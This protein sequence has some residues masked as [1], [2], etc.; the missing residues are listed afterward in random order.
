M[1][2][3]HACT[4]QAPDRA[5][6]LL[7][8]CDTLRNGRLGGPGKSKTALRKKRLAIDWSRRTVGQVKAVWIHH[9]PSTATH[10]TPPHLVSHAFGL[11]P[12]DSPLPNAVRPGC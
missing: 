7:L 6:M 3:R 11:I 5:G 2:L 9:S 12:L 4:G 8:I 10:L 1:C